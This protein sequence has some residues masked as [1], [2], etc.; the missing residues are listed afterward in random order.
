MP[1]FLVLT[2][3]DRLRPI[4]EWQPPYYWQQGDR[5]KERNIREAVKYRQ[6]QMGDQVQQ[7]FP[8]VTRSENEGR[9]GWGSDELAQQLVEAI[10]PAKSQRLA[11]FLRSRDARITAAARL[12]E[13]YAIQM[14]SSQGIVALVK[15]PLF[16]FLSARFTGTPELGML[17]AQSVPA[18][19]VPVVASKMMLTY[20]LA[21]LLNEQGNLFR[22]GEILTL[23]PLLLL[24]RR[25]R[26]PAQNAWAWG[27]AL[28]EY[29]TKDLSTQALPSRFDY[30]LD[31][32]AAMPAPVRE[33]QTHAAAKSA[34]T[35]EG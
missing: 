5:P 33:A 14:T 21:G 4:R 27:Q 20:E 30:Y 10:A 16:A 25:D 32:Q 7:V 2:Q 3:V 34:A 19:Q 23:W 35:N 24:D 29:W 6:E 1:R 12:I 28:I 18:E 15:T 26:P 11:K 13:R 17:L 22:P 9:E 31:Q 8:V